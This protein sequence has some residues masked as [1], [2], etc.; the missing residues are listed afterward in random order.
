MVARGCRFADRIATIAD[1]IRDDRGGRKSVPRPVAITD[2]TFKAEV[3]ESDKPVL[4][5]FWAQWCGPCKVLTPVLEEVADELARQIKVAKVDVDSNPGAAA[6][7]GVQSIPTLIL[8]KNGKPAARLVGAMP[9]GQI[10]ERLAPHL[11]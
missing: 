10:L 4:V 9:K 7:F 11:M 8:F 6:S 3:Y 2:A 1:R 5:D